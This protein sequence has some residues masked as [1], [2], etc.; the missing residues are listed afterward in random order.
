MKKRN[1]D[2]FLPANVRQAKQVRL[3][4]EFLEDQIRL[5][6]TFYR[7]AKMAHSRGFDAEL[8]IRVDGQVCQA[9]VNMI[10]GTNR[11]LFEYLCNWA[12][13]ERL[14]AVVRLEDFEKGLI[15]LPTGSRGSHGEDFTG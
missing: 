15:H 5:T 8:I 13:G 7:F 3:R 2:R 6:E 12:A 14:K 11:E 1:W 10:S 9:A 4:R